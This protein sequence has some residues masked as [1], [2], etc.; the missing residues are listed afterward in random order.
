VATSTVNL[1]LNP[2]AVTV[3]NNSTVPLNWYRSNWGLASTIFHLSAGRTDERSLGI[4]MS[5]YSS[6]DAK[7]YFNPVDVTAGQTYT[8]SFWYKSSA[9][10]ETLVEY[11]LSDGTKSHNWL[12]VMPNV[13]DWTEVT[14][15]IV[16]PANVTR[17]TTQNVI[18]SNGTLE[19]DDVSLRLQ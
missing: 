4:T 9:N 17:I 2:S 14:R 8:Y 19:V 6:G 11:F 13:S 5:N 1:I 18:R 15:S 3:P 12:G 7:W 10:S 16:I